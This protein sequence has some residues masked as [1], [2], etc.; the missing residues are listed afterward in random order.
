MRAPL[1]ACSNCIIFFDMSNF[2]S[3]VPRA[4]SRAVLGNNTLAPSDPC[5]RLCV[6]IKVLPTVKILFRNDVL[7]S[8]VGDKSFLRH[9]FRPPAGYIII[10]IAKRLGSSTYAVYR[11]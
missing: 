7:T 1:V 4:F 2:V 8:A 3:G 10:E 9:Q 11:Y 6:I 5:L